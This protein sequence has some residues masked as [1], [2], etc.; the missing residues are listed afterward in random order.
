MKYNLKIISLSL[1]FNCIAETALEWKPAIYNQHARRQRS[2]ASQALT[3]L[4]LQGN[5]TILDIGCG[6]GKITSTIADLVPDGRVLATDISET[7]IHFA[8][9]NFSS[10]KNLN[11]EQLDATLLDKQETF[12]VITSFFSLHWIKEKKTV[13]EAMVKALKK[14][15]RIFILATINAHQPFIE[16]YKKT[17]Q[18]PQW[19]PFFANYEWPLYLVNYNKTVKQLKKLSCKILTAQTTTKFNIFASRQQFL[20][21]L[22]ALPLA[23]TQL[24]P[25]LHCTFLNE[26]IDAYLCIYPANEDGSINYLCPYCV[27]EAQ[28]STE[29]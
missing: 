18:Q 26:V 10:V 28:K 8:Q 27:I 1:I 14:E 16:A 6:D 7:M 20:L 29:S 22:Q 21:H 17:M 12:N 2:V 23:L 19:K 25:Q 15:G 5:E 11:F 13:L 9:E 24:P 3:K 4:N